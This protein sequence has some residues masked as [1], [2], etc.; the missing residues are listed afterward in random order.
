MNLQQK[1]TANAVIQMQENERSRIAKELHDGI[2][3]YLSTLKIN[4]QALE[5]TVPP[6]KTP[7]YKNNT[8]LI[9]QTSD[10]LRRVTKNLSNETLQESG[11]TNALNEL[12]ERI[13]ASGATQI[14]FLVN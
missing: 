6:G 9:D 8:E 13:N 7:L 2:G 14:N 11:L 3:T 5:N 12:K 1:H 4:L 10:E